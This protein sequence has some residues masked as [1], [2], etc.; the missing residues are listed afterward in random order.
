LESDRSSREGSCSGLESY[1]GPA[2]RG[3]RGAL[4][5]HRNA[6]QSARQT[7][8]HSHAWADEAEHGRDVS[9]PHSE[10]PSSVRLSARSTGGGEGTSRT[11]TRIQKALKIL[12]V[13]PPLHSAELRQTTGEG[14]WAMNAHRPT[15]ASPRQSSGRDRT[16][17]FG[18]AQGEPDPS[19][20]RRGDSERETHARQGQKDQAARAAFLDQ[21]PPLADAAMPSRIVPEPAPKARERASVHFDTQLPSQSTETGSATASTAILWTPRGT[22]SLST[23]RL[24]TPRGTRVAASPATPEE[25]MSSHCRESSRNE[26]RRNGAGGGGSGSRGHE[27]EWAEASAVHAAASLSQLG[28]G[29]SGELCI[30]AMQKG[31]SSEGGGRRRQAES[32]AGPWMHSSH[33]S[34][35]SI[36]LSHRSAHSASSKI[37]LDSVRHREALAKQVSPCPVLMPCSDALF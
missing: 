20:L 26:S 32:V 16:A 21:A 27:D 4:A 13:C 33:A 23:P 28:V 11:L 19:T 1:F 17:R 9:A 18:S 3:E 10:R 14:G 24:S 36:P 35:A 37:S 22:A 2:C 5:W 12:E 34:T 7:L 8:A 15:L 6:A 29:A 25:F 31:S 30:S